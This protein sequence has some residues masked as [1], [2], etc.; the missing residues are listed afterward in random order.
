MKRFIIMVNL[1]SVFL[2]LLS[3]RGYA[4][5]IYNSEDNCTATLS[6]DMLLHVPIITFSGKTYRA[7]FQY[8]VNTM[9]FEIK[10]VE[11]VENT[12][13][14]SDCEPATLSSAL[15]LF[16]PLVSFNG[17]SYWVY[18]VYS[19][20]LLFTLTE[21]NVK[22]N[23]NVNGDCVQV[24]QGNSTVKVVNSGNTMIEVYFGSSV[25]F[26]ADIGSGECNL[27]G[28]ELPDSYTLRTDVEITQCTPS[29]E[30][31]CD[32]LFEPKKYVFLTLSR[33]QSKTITVGRDFFN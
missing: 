15:K 22:N 10:N 9:D 13:S 7:D 30:G 24:S 3:D 23:G 32:T 27:V 33:G 8:V 11:L 2:M 14:F 31:G 4:E 19:H 17:V 29:E 6:S 12:S 28:I 21:G 1:L 20:D 5:S 26:G 25:G 18:L 16:I